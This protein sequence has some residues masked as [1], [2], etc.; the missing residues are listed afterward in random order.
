MVGNLSSLVLS[1]FSTS[2]I[3]VT[4][5]DTWV[6]FL[7]QSQ[8]EVGPT[9][10]KTFCH[11]HGWYHAQDYYT[12]SSICEG[13]AKENARN[14]YDLYVLRHFSPRPL[15]TKLEWAPDQTQTPPLAR[16]NSGG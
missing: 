11:L 13:N 1:V 5:F 7:L 16:R 12:Y 2:T 8:Q 15:G 14:Y 10:S 9:L 3:P 4:V 6:L